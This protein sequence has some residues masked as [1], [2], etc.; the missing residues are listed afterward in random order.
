[1]IAQGALTVLED[2]AVRYSQLN[3]RITTIT[4]H[5]KEKLWHQISDEL[6]AYFKE[7]AFDQG[8]NSDLLI[9]YESLV[10]GLTHKLNPIKYAILTILATRQHADIELSI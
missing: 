10:K 5:F 8:E 1:M 6:V 3:D 2:H 9:L 7:K 4:L